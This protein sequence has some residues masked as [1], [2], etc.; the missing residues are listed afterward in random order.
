MKG[1]LRGRDRARE[2]R[3]EEDRKKVGTLFDGI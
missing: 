1:G 2:K 3:E